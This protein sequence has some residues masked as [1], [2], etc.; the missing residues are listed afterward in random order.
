MGLSGPLHLVAIV[1]WVALCLGSGTRPAVATTEDILSA[2]GAQDS[3]ERSLLDLSLE[4][5][6]D[7]EVQVA[8]AEPQSTREAPAV[9]TV[10]TRQEIELSG[11]RD[12][13]DVLRRVSGFDFGVDVWGVV[14]IGFRGHWGHEGK[15]ML[16][17]DGMI[18]NEPMYG[19]LAFGAHFP[20]AQIERI[21]I[22]RGPG[23]VIHGNSAELAVI[24]VI[25]KIGSEQ[26]G[27]RIGT[28]GGM[29]EGGY[30]RLNLDASYGRAGGAGAD[31]VAHSYFGVSVAG[32]TAQR[33]TQTY[34][35]IYGDAY[36]MN[37]NQDLEDRQARD[38]VSSRG[39][40]R[41]VPLR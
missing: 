30:S 8:S 26:P 16:A 18:M 14:G 25:T 15:I 36:D 37:G 24:N 22:I 12:L 3:R 17:V 1:G 6:L 35:D 28:T 2:R 39:P 4:E 41:A 33:S 10:V 21:E 38:A 31:G 27:L 34:T 23:S 20:I 11:A 40:A 29:F 5:L 19:N 9:V 7:L 32:A 13:I